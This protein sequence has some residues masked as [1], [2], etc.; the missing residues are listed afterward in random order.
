MAYAAKVSTE[1]T[2][3]AHRL[4]KV[5]AAH[6]AETRTAS[7]A[8][9][10]LMEDTAHAAAAEFADR[11]AHPDS[12]KHNFYPNEPHPVPDFL[13]LATFRTDNEEQYVQA[14]ATTGDAHDDADEGV[15]RA[16]ASAKA[17]AL[18]AE[19]AAAAAAEAQ[20]AKMAAW[21]TARNHRAE[22]MSADAQ[23]EAAD[24][25]DSKA[26]ALANAARAAV[27]QAAAVDETDIDNA[28]PER[29]QAAEEAKAAVRLSEA[30]DAKE[31]AASRTARKQAGK[32]RAAE[33]LAKNAAAAAQ[34][35]AR[36]AAEA[37]HS[38]QVAAAEE[39]AIYDAE[40]NT[41]YNPEGFF[42]F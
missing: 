33:E 29:A 27:Y 11:D 35:H 17:A 7:Q 13:Q 8:A 41:N 18:E 26:D 30:A 34:S 12:E 23:G 38:A 28:E 20:A 42:F 6:A 24:L 9:A 32:G 15:Q 40:L 39:A 10:V 16:A 21:E 1:E 25:A 2:E 5:S 3:E 22:K 31:R 14:A 4:A 36:D 19:A 37:E